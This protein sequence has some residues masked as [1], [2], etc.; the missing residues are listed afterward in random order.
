VAKSTRPERPVGVVEFSSSVISC[1]EIAGAVKHHKNHLIAANEACVVV[2]KGEV[3]VWDMHDTAYGR[4]LCT[5]SMK[6]LNNPPEPSQPICWWSIPASS[7]KPKPV[8]TTKDDPDDVLV[9]NA[10]LVILAKDGCGYRIKP[11]YAQAISILKDDAKV[12]AW[13]ITFAAELAKR[14]GADM[15]RFCREMRTDGLAKF[16]DF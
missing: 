16:L 6:Y 8:V 1:S 4:A 3:L 2:P 7:Q 5:S 10:A 9:Q 11:K 12:T 14:D 15:T 13:R